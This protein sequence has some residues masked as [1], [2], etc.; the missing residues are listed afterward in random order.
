MI[1]AVFRTIYEWLFGKKGRGLGRH[2]KIDREAL[3]DAA[4]D[5]LLRDG[6]A[7]LTIEA[8]A[9]NAGISKAS[10]LYDYKTKQALVRAMI[11][12]RFE[13]EW[14][15][16]RS[17]TSNLESSPDAG[18]QGW[19]KASRR[20]LSDEDRML[21]MGMMVALAGDPEFKQ[22]SQRFFE[23]MR[24]TTV[25]T[26]TQPRGARLALLAV[27]G[28]KLLDFLGLHH[29]PRDE[30]EEILRDIA[31]LAGQ[32]PQTTETSNPSSPPSNESPACVA[33]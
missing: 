9:A 24:G 16:V 4:Q 19:I 14:E 27:E 11:E 10:V 30:C 25:D 33:P 20:E 21:A 26:A 3:L 23:R 1:S 17:I 22:L 32:E 13:T 8:V 15:R 6:A 18:I 2:R 7:N 29:W 5:V 28:L 12:R 31:W